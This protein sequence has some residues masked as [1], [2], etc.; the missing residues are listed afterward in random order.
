M[1]AR[2]PE[3]TDAVLDQWEASA[4][5][6]EEDGRTWSVHPLA[7]LAIVAEVR[8]LRSAAPVT[9]ADL[10]ER[11]LTERQHTINTA[12]LPYLQ[13]IRAEADYVHGESEELRDAVLAYVDALNG[14]S[15]PTVEEALAHVRHELADVVLAATVLA[16]FLGTTVEACIAEKTERDRGRG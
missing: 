5:I 2:L 11:Y 16:G 13:K 14:W 7:V 3:I 9:L 6:D 1:T 8:R 4:A 15:G 10:L 12:H